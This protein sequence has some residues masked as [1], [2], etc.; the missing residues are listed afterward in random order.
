MIPCK[1]L[2]RMLW[3][4][5]GNTVR[6]DLHACRPGNWE[7]HHGYWATLWRMKGMWL[8]E[9]SR[10]VEGPGICGV[11]EMGEWQ[12]G[13][14]KTWAR[15]GCWV[16]K[17]LRTS[18]SSESTGQK[19]ET[20]SE[21]PWVL[22]QHPGTHQLCELPLTRELWRGRENEAG[23]ECRENYAQ[24]N[25]QHMWEKW[26]VGGAYLGLT[27]LH[28]RVGND[29]RWG[30]CPSQSENVLFLCWDWGWELEQGMLGLESVAR[31]ATDFRWAAIVYYARHTSFNLI[32]WFQEACGSLYEN[33]LA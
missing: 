28:V 1:N 16:T 2:G 33:R 19:H 9:D 10:A 29:R 15:K 14:R 26:D 11:A 5:P 31:N 7:M 8:G 18:G 12:R 24:D 21:K 27:A 22:T 3:G 13:K 32:W 20:E 6:K 25:C 17:K 30:N 4:C 23:E